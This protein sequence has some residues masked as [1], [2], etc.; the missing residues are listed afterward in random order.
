MPRAAHQLRESSRRAASPGM[1]RRAT[2]LARIPRLA[3]QVEDDRDRP[4]VDELDGHRGA[5]DAA[6]HGHAERLE[7]GAEALV[8]RLR[9]LRRRRLREAGPVALAG[10]GEE[11]EL[12]DDERS[13]AGVEQAPVE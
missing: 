12:G 6:L 13:A 9:L 1:H 11:R 8:E 2:Y 5:E 7:V 10:V 3:L 4:V